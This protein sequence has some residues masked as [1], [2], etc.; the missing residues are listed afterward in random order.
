QGKLEDAPVRKGRVL[1]GRRRPAAPAAPAAGQQHPAQH[2]AREPTAS[3]DRPF[4]EAPLAHGIPR[5]IDVRTANLF[6]PSRTTGVSPVA[7]SGSTGE[8]PVVRFDYR[9]WRRF[10][11]YFAMTR[12]IVP[13]TSV[14]R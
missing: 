12:S 11:R 2:D 10:P 9:S 1:L 13:G 8:T 14:P 6:H 5:T 3:H 7:T 4:V